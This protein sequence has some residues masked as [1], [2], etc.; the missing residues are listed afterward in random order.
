MNRTLALSL[1]LTIVACNPEPDP[2]ISADPTPEDAAADVPAELPEMCRKW[3][4]SDVRRLRPE[5]NPG[6]GRG[7]IC[8]EYRRRS[9]EVE[10]MCES[11]AQ[12]NALRWARKAIRSPRRMGGVECESEVHGGVVERTGECKFDVYDSD[13]NQVAVLYAACNNTAS[14]D[15]TCVLTR[16]ERKF[17]PAASLRPTPEEEREFLEEHRK[18][19]EKRRR[20]CIPLC[21]RPE[22][23][24]LCLPR[25]CLEKRI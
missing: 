6:W 19:L 16:E 2:V 8:D 15:V 10:I 7:M 17:V 1:L 12:R 23:A 14:T 25:C 5:E 24:P 18:R 13:D 11:H 4:P 21:E 3:E 9:G 22:F 20:V